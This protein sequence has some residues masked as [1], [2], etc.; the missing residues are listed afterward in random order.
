MAGFLLVSFVAGILTVLAPCILPLL[1]VIVGGSLTG[2]GGSLKR[3]FVIVVSLGASVFLFTL[4]LKATTVFI[5][6]P[7]LFWQILSGGLLLIFGIVTVFPSIWDRIPGIQNLYRS[8]NKVLGAGYKKQNIVG[9]A[10][11]GAALG[12]V[13]SSCSPTYFVILAAVLPAHTGEG[14]AYLLAYSIGLSLSL[15][16]VAILGQKAA[17][18]MGIAA[19]PN[20]WFKKAI[21][22]LF[23][24]VGLAVIFGIDK[25][26]EAALPSGAFA[27]I[28]IEQK[29]LSGSQSNP[30][31]QTATSTQNS[32]SPDFVSVAAKALR[33][34]QAPELVS[35]DGYINT[36]GEPVTL[37]QYRGKNVV[38]VD[39]WD[40]SCINCQR[41]FPY[42]KAW[43]EKYNGQGLVIVG[44]HTPEFAF[45]QLKAN[46]EAA[47]QKAGLT[48]PIV[49]DNE[50]K[51]WQA[52]QNQYWPR[53]YLIDID[54]Y[55]VH[56][57]AGE[58]DYDETEKAI[59]AA[60][61]ERSER[62]G[63]GTVST[64][65]VDMPEADLSGVRSPETYFGSSRN[66][67]LGNGTPGTEGAQNF[68]LPDF[69]QANTL[70]LGGSWN[71]KPE[72]A[73]ASSGASILYV[74]ASSNVYMVAAPEG[75]S[76]KIHVL[77]DGKPLGALSGADVDA[78][79]STV[80]VSGD[81]LYTL[82][83]AATPGIHV[84]RI[85]IIDGTLDAYTFT[86][87]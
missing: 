2:E 81:R 55:I 25:K 41:T 76:A 60:L 32:A 20:G 35:P 5:A 59:Q 62:L 66:E 31:A 58:G 79:A 36:D 69:P 7:A 47:A 24:A 86:F 77:L 38:L 70:Y 6:V 23:I 16:V 48:Y 43:N 33:Y 71:I 75:A 42:L 49:L 73:A 9:D 46:V 39:F 67:F 14:I 87:G 56:D 4:A 63:T 1:P 34:P 50:Y 27:E 53:E 52:F 21:G 22:I 37:A 64:S 57:H 61:L 74:Y 10:I 82:V 3:A 84:L 40:Y 83:H 44:I 19:D 85:Q 13:F 45:E 65:T 54:G 12:P 15:F 11:V 17:G 80:T 8:S 18:V 78:A 68:T 28:G 26:I 29:L 72:Y 51:T 30:S